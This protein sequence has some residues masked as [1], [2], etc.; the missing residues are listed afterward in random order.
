[1][2]PRIMVVNRLETHEVTY[3]YVVPENFDFSKVQSFHLT[4]EEGVWLGYLQGFNMVD[5]SKNQ[6]NS[7]RVTRSRVDQGLVYAEI[8]DVY[9]IQ[10]Q[11]VL[12][13]YCASCGGT[14]N[15]IVYE[16]HLDRY[17]CEECGYVCYGP[18]MD[19]V[20]NQFE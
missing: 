7:E 2:S 5:P 4:A 3:T 17:G 9:M 6:P 15:C 1:M 8:N 11:N 16:P 13:S 12:Q 20:R 18:D 19:F 10:D 14:H